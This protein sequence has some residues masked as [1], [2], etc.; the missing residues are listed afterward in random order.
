MFTTSAK[1]K[2]MNA[3][4]GCSTSVLPTSYKVGL[5]TTTP[6]ASGSNITEPASSTGYQRSSVSFGSASDGII[7]NSSAVEFPVLAK[8]AGV[9]T[10]YVLYDQN[11]SPFWFDALKSSRTLETDTVVTFA[12]GAIELTLKNATS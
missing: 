10:H 2:V 6:T 3:V 12:T 4:F 5:S 1:N 11:G 8:D 7:K 9:V